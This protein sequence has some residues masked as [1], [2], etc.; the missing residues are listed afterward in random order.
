MLQHHEVKHCIKLVH[1]LDTEPWTH[2][3][4]GVRLLAAVMVPLCDFLHKKSS[5]HEFVQVAA[6]IA[7]AIKQLEALSVLHRDISANNIGIFEGRG[8]L[9]DFSAGKVGESTLFSQFL[10][11]HID[12]EPELLVLFCCQSCLLCFVAWLSR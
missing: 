5:V 9:F 12:P 8:V 3:A 11:N 4:E 1:V 2:E 7:A 6:D 10:L